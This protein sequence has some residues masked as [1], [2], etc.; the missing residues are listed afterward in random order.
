MKNT[1]KMKME[2]A[3]TPKT[4]VTYHISTWSQS[5]EE[6]DLNLHCHEN[7]TS[8]INSQ[9]VST[10]VSFETEQFLIHKN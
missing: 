7:L 8:F 10:N 9:I 4:L 5:P 3:W 1:F 2:A 6:L